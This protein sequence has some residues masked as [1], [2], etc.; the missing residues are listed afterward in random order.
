[1]LAAAYSNS[2]QQVSNQNDES[3]ESVLLQ[4]KPFTAYYHL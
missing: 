2:F 4:L 3:P 1:M